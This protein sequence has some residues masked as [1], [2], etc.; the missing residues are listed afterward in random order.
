[1]PY[2]PAGS[3]V[4]RYSDIEMAQVKLDRS[5]LKQSAQKTV[6]ITGAAR[7][8][9]AATARLFNNFGAN[10]ILADLAELKDAAEVLQTQLA[11]PERAKFVPTNIV[12]WTELSASFEAAIAKFGSIDIVIANAGIMESH[13][14]FDLDA[15]DK[16]GRLLENEDAGRVIDV[17]LK[18]TLNTLRLGLHYMKSDPEGSNKSILLVASTSSYFGGTGVGAYIASKH[19]VLGLLRASQDVARKNGVR[20]NAVAPFFTPTH[21]TA[22]FSERWGQAGLER[23][24]PDG[25]AEAIALVA[26]DSARQGHC[27][28]VAG[29]YLREL[30]ETRT[31]LFSSWLGEEVTEFM[32]SAMQFLVSIGGYVLPK[33]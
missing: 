12:N 20:V 17:N 32:A 13:P 26:S 9:G 4:I 19:G 21:I 5:L 29:R 2:C 16:D 11:H 28:L 22:G 30:E 15:V 7:G 33:R 25:V 6:L 24:T 14:V 27:I 31:K 8:I 3:K 1:M 10:V 18:G 23:N